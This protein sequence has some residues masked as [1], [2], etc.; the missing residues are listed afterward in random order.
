MKCVIRGLT[1]L[2]S[3]KKSKMKK[4]HTKTLNTK[5]NNLCISVANNASGDILAE[6]ETVKG[7]LILFVKPYGCPGPLLLY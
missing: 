5:L 1:I 2:H 4:Q 7:L 3:F 6:Y